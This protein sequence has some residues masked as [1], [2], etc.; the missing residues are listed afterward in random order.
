MDAKSFEESYQSEGTTGS[1]CAYFVPNFTDTGLFHLDVAPTSAW[2]A[3]YPTVRLRYYARVPYL[4]NASDTL[5]IPSA[6]EQYLIW[7]ARLACCLSTDPDGNR[8]A[9]ARSKAEKIWQELVKLDRENDF[10]DWE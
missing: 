3:S 7:E 4:A 8:M 9:M 2:V 1:P 5:P 6:V 10:N